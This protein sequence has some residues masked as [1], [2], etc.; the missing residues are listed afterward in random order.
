MDILDSA[1]F[2]LLL[3]E[4]FGSGGALQNRIRF[5]CHSV[6][7]SQRDKK[8]KESVRD[9]PKCLKFFIEI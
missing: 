9:K 6:L 8:Q 3:E 2:G 1:L 7:V 4:N 5:L